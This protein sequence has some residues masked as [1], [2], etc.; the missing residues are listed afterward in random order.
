MEKTVVRGGDKKR[1]GEYV[2]SFLSKCY[3]FLQK[4][5]DMPKNWV[6]AFFPEMNYA[7]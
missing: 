6:K 5:A 4:E 1:L 3:F 2:G 7:A